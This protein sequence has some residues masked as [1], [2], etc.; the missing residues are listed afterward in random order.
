MS[1]T[2][3]IESVRDF[4]V[5]HP[6]LLTIAADPTTDELFVSYK[7]KAMFG[8]FEGGVVA[9]AV[10]EEG[11]KGAWQQ[12]S[13]QMMASVGI[14][15][16]TGGKFV[17]GVLDAVQTIGESLSGNQTKHGK[18]KTSRGSRRGGRKEAV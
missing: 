1:T 13:S 16:D 12:F 3:K 8:K 9:R 4:A 17:N 14:D 11:F 15:Q 10:T 6:D 2:S 5:D 7:G 18:S